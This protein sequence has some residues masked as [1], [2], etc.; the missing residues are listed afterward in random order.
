MGI[1]ML[2]GSSH[3]LYGPKGIGC[4][5]IKK[6]L[7][8]PCLL[9]GGGQE[10]KLRA[11]T[12]NVP[13]IVGFGKACELAQQ[14]MARRKEHL[15][16]LSRR[17]REGIANTIPN[18]L[19]T[20]HPSQRIPGFVSVCFEFVEGESILLMLDSYGI[21]ASSGSA[22][23]SGALDPSHV[24]LALGLPHEIVHGSLRLTPGKDNTEE[25]VDRVLEVL[26]G[27]IANLRRISP[28]S[29]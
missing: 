16:K 2:S 1:D 15:E 25:D 11:G 4:L 6:G 27:I 28:F 29:N 19:L 22:C 10:G 3:K 8:V 21:M 17:L 7:R 23:T 9:H 13:A 26:P 20:G 5:F 24:L 12:E 14:N 18:A